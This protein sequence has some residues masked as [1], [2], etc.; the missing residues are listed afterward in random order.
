VIYVYIL[1]SLDLKMRDIYITL[2]RVIYIHYIVPRDIHII[3]FHVMK[4]LYSFAIYIHMYMSYY[5]YICI[6]YIRP[7]DA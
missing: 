3:L 5:S 7:E 6:C 2:F 1:Y 4:I